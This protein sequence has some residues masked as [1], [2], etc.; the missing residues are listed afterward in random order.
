VK[1]APDADLF[2]VDA[3]CRFG[4]PVILRHPALAAEDRTQE[5]LRVPPEETGR[6]PS[7]L[8]LLPKE[9][10]REAETNDLLRV[11]Q[12]H[13]HNFTANRKRGSAQP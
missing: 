4:N 11:V 13:R 7:R 1:D 8:F 3:A 2:V 5:G 10:D 12:L 9:P 6:P